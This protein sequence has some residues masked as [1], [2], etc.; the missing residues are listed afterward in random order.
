MNFIRIGIHHVSSKPEV[1]RGGNRSESAVLKITKA[2]IFY[3]HYVH[4]HTLYDVPIRC[5]VKHHFYE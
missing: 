5:H 2:Y 3:R 1:L 4:R